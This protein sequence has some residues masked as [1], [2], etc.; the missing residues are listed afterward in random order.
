MRLLDKVIDKYVNYSRIACSFTTSL[1]L[2]LSSTV[3]DVEIFTLAPMQRKFS[4]CCGASLV[5]L[6]LGFVHKQL[7][8]L[9]T[10]RGR[11]FVGRFL[12]PSPVGFL[13]FPRFE[14]DHTI[15]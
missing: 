15:S 10:R 11:F 4:M 8:R 3:S 1:S 14:A 2:G 12:R 6:V 5:I 9:E 7:L 13:R